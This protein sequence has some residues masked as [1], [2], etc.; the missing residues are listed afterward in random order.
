MPL[1]YGL[2]AASLGA[3]LVLPACG[4]FRRDRAGDVPIAIDL[5]TA[6]R[7]QIETL[8]G[9]TPSMAR[10]IVD[11]RPYAAPDDLV[12][13]GIL[14]ERELGRIRDRVTVKGDDG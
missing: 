3:V 2:V 10:R 1:R 9:I 5:N 4:L 7:R 11:E 13:R 14:T 6:S 12:E 8:P